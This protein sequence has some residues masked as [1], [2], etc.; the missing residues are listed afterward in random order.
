MKEG[1]LLICLGSRQRV[2]IEYKGTMG[3]YKRPIEHFTIQIMHNSRLF[4]HKERTSAP[5]RTR[6]NC[7]VYGE[8]YVL[9]EKGASRAVEKAEPS[10]LI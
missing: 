5:P 1:R 8:T 7:S 4:H 6:Q 9:L 10:V 3:M 2:S